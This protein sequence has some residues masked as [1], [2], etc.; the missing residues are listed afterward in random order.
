MKKRVATW[1]KNKTTPKKTPKAT[2]KKRTEAK[3]W[4]E[5]QSRLMKILEASGMNTEN[6]Q[7]MLPH[8]HDR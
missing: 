3:H 5:S 8:S 6:K 4:I 1:H 2:D 7:I